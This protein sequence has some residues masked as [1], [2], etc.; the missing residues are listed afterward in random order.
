MIAFFDPK[1]IVTR[2]V[3]QCLDVGGVRTETVFGNDEL[4]MR[5]ILA[6]LGHEAL[7]GI[8][9]TVIFLRAI[10]LDNGLGHQRND[11]TAVWMENRRPQ[12]LVIIGD[13]TIAMD[14]VETRVTVNRLR[15]TIPRAI[16]CQELIAVKKY[17]LLQCLT[18][19]ELTKDARERCP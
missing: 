16:E 4:E 8:A 5:V 13:R 12:Q 3:M 10:L 15:G 11:F 9:L 1:D 17:H 19:L 14:L 7:G 6:Q 2:G 18:A